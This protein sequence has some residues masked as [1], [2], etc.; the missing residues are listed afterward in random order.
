M[1]VILTSECFQAGGVICVS[2]GVITPAEIYLVAD[3]N[4]YGH[5]YLLIGYVIDWI[6]Y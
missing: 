3:Q 1:I 5:C 2:S 4:D 6:K